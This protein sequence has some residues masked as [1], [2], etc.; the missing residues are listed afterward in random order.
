[1]TKKLSRRDLFKALGAAGLL[2]A[3]PAETIAPAPLIPLAP[4]LDRPE[5]S[6]SVTPRVENISGY[7]FRITS[8]E[9]PSLILTGALLEVSMTSNRDEIV[10]TSDSKPNREYVAGMQRNECTL[11]FHPKNVDVLHDMLNSQRCNALISVGD[12]S[13]EFDCMILEARVDLPYHGETEVSMDVAVL[14][15]VSYE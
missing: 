13:L 12:Q 10:T 6:V 15:D 14:G 2:A 11:R 7:D 4:P 5:P 1:M 3:L 9:D 8:M